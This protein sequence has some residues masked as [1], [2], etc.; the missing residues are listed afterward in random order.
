MLFGAVAAAALLAA[1]GGGGAPALPTTPPS[2]GPGSPATS[3]SA[4][5]AVVGDTFAF[6]GSSIENDVY[7]YP[8]GSPFPNTSTATKIS[9]NVVVTASTN[10]LGGGGTDFHSSTTTVGT[11]ATRTASGDSYY[12]TV[13]AGNGTNFVLNA[14]QSVDDTKNSYAWTYTTPQILDELPESAGATWTNSPAGSYNETDADGATIARTT[15]A[16]GSYTENDTFATGS[17]PKMSF[18]VNPDGSGAWNIYFLGSPN[19]SIVSYTAPTAGTIS[20]AVLNPTPTPSPGATGTPAPNLPVVIATPPAWFSPSAKL[21]Q[22]SDTVSTGVSFPAS[23]AV[24]SSFGTSGNSIAQVIT[25]IDPIFGLDEVTTTT[26]YTAQGFGPVCVAMNDVQTYYYDYLNDTAGSA[27]L[28]AYVG[29]PQ[30]TKTYAQTLTLQTAGTAIQSSGRSTKSLGI[31]PIAPALFAAD[32]TNFRMHI[33]RE[34][35]QARTAF[36]KML[37]RSAPA[38]FFGGNR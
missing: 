6:S 30:L 33:A 31:A 35:A 32:R 27:G 24:P 5:P 22:E 36:A 34:R 1:C 16:D 12:S 13:S 2:T 18:T 26:T 28:A 9:E 11:S 29:T 10:P 37:V 8:V 7:T 19:P 14:Q 17:V 21:Y 20:V 15:N 25:K 3:S 4:R 38:L 23:C